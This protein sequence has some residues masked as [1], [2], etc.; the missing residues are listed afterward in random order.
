MRKILFVPALALALLGIQV[1]RAAV[2]VPI[3]QVI[4]VPVSIASS[5]TTSA[6]IKTGGASL[7]GIQLPSALT[8]TA[9]TFTVSSDCVTYVALYNAS[10]AVSYTIAAS[11][12]MAINPVDFYGAACFKI[13][14]GSSEAAGRT[15]TATLKGI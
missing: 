2:T 8:S 9:V 14:L 4:Q 7:V 11:Q 1:A 6:A 10:G 15:L 5:G 3:G 13:V 12:F